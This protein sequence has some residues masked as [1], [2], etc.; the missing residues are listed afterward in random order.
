MTT[1]ILRAQLAVCFAFSWS[2]AGAFDFQEVRRE[3]ESLAARSFV[4][5]TNRTSESLAQLSYLGHQAIKFNPGK[6]LW[7]QAGLPFQLEFFHPGYSA[8]QMPPLYEIADDQ[9]RLIPFQ[10]GL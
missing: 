2:T 6:A 4:P 10:S 5:A 3:A 7:R 8:L 1:K 9:V